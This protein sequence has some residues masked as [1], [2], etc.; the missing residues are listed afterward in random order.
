MKDAMISIRNVTK[1]FPGIVANDNISLEI[2]KGE[3]FALLGEN[4]AGKSVLMS[5]IFG[6]YEPDE[7]DIWIKGQRVTDYSPR[8]AARMG[9]GM[10][11]QHFKLV[12]NYT[13]A[14]NIVL[15]MEPVKK[16]LGFLPLVNLTESEKE[17][18]ALSHRYKLDV[19]PRARIEQVNVATRQKVEILKMLYREADI[20]IF[21]EPT[22]ILTPQEIEYLL[23]IIRELRENG[24]T[25]I[26][27]SHK[28]EEIKEVADRCAILN[29]GRLVDIR[30]V[31]TTSTREMANLM[32][33]REVML[34]VNKPAPAFGEVVLEVE[35]LRVKNQDQVEV[36][37]GVSFQIRGGEIF[38][39]A[40]VSGNGQAEIAEAITGLKPVTDGTIRLNQVEITHYPV[41]QRNL[42]GI[43]YIPED[44]Q[45]YG[46]ILEDP[47]TDNLALKRYF[48]EPF[49]T[50]G[51]K[52]RPEAFVSYARRLID[53]YDIR[54]NRGEA[55]ITRSLSG[56]NQQKMII[57]REIEQ[58]TPLIIFVQPTRG[59]DVG[60]IENTWQQIL[61]EREKGKAILLI[62]L[63]LDEIMALADTI[64]VIY[65]GEMLEIQ[66]ASALTAMEIGA[67]MMGVKEHE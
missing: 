23:E 28:L 19:N 51:G 42:E 48:Q 59:L 11:H 7:G 6:L 36:V 66:P 18:E 13:I 56:G 16:T 43:A 44:R 46:L 45:A 38:A 57:A 20:L 17:I 9:V 60:A 50:P 3:I 52:L 37:K 53:T 33:G 41:R 63:E 39:I 35:N 25:I 14:Q 47:I 62:S 8:Q 21:D 54:S 22:A 27:V 4:G 40:G 61:R 12:E 24:K 49:S 34:E 64:G 65:N 67:Y 30:D 15:G 55:S 31:A 58:D 10:V 29:R 32:V 2:R 1:R 26:L 5:M